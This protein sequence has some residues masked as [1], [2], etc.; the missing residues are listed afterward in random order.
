VQATGAAHPLTRIS[1]PPLACFASVPE[2]EVFLKALPGKIP[3]VGVLNRVFR[4]VLV[5]AH[6]ASSDNLMILPTQFLH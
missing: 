2:H 4:V 3:I 6:S 5:A 1:P